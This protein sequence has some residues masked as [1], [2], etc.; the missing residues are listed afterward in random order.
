MLKFTA[1]RAVFYLSMVSE[2]VSLLMALLLL[3]R[4][5]ECLVTVTENETDFFCHSTRH[6]QEQVHVC[7]LW[8]D[9]GLLFFHITRN[10]KS[11]CFSTVPYFLGQ[12]TVVITIVSIVNLFLK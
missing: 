10:Q 4:S 1:S 12:F 3:P 5:M 11:F 7:T 6:T 2:L 9:A 8:Y